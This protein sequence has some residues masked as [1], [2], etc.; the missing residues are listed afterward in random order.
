MDAARIPPLENRGDQLNAV[1][2][3]GARRRQQVVLPVLEGRAVAGKAL[4]QV[5]GAGS[6]QP[7]RRDGKGDEGPRSRSQRTTRRPRYLKIGMHACIIWAYKGDSVSEGF[8][9]LAS[10]GLRQIY[11]RAT[12][13]TRAY[14]HTRVYSLNFQT[15]IHLCIFFFEKINISFAFKKRSSSLI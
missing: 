6:E 10:R 15:Y 2:E 7:T 4:E 9:A 13:W 5:L 14:V 11:A 1:P 3:V 8:W 12:M